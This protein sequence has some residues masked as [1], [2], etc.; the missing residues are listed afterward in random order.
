M[1]E[2]IAE[3]DDQLTVRYLE[4]SEIGVEELKAALRRAVLANKA[5]PCSAVPR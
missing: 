5:Y 1:L 3:L 4:G 2:K